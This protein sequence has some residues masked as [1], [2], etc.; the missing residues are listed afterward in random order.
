MKLRTL[1]ILFT[2]LSLAAFAALGTAQASGLRIIPKPHKSYSLS[3]YNTHTQERLLT[4]YRTG[5]L[6]HEAALGDISW[7][8]RDHRS[9]E[10]TDINRDL[11]GYLSEIKTVLADRY[12]HKEIEFHIISGYRSPKTNS[13]MRAA[14]GGQA[15][16]SR[17]MF[18]DAIDIRI[19]GV[20]TSEIRDIA[21]CL[22]KGGVGYYRG[23]DFVH[24]D[25]WK[26]RHW[27]WAPTAN[28]CS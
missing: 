8:M 3:F 19:P 25:T 22:Q 13:R 4:T 11:L 14:G 7:I 28:T 16:S 9:G 6:Y 15:K 12:P 24:I 17:H 26:I 21:W 27:N 20:P 18:G 1:F 5:G 2:I 23:S 10:V